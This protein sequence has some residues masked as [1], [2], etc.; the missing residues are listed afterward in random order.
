MSAHFTPHLLFHPRR[1]IMKKVAVISIVLMLCSSFAYAGELIV[2]S[3]HSDP[4]PKE[5]F[6]MLV[7]EFEKQNPDID[8]K[9]NTTAHEEYKKSIRIW[10]ASDNPPDV[11]TW[12]AGNRAMFF[13]EKD[14]IMDISDVWESAGL[15]DKFPKAFQSISF[16]DGKA[17]FLPDTYYWWAVYYRKSIFD[18]KGLTPPKTW[19]ELMQVCATLK[20]AGITPFTIGTKYR[21]TAA[22]WFDYFDMRVNGTK[23]HMDLMFGKVPYNDPKVAKAF[24]PW[25][26]MLDKGYFLENA[27]SYSWQEALQFMVRGEAAM[28]LMGQFIMDSVPEEVKADMDF[29]QFPIIDANVPVGE[30]A[31]TD[32]YMIPKKARNPEAAKK[33]MA[34]LASEQAQRIQVEKTG[35]I[36]TN[37][38]IPLD[39]YPEATQKG[40]QMMQSV[41]ELAQFYD[42]DT[43]PEMA[44]KGMDGMM[45]FWYKPGN[46]GKIL[47]RLE[48]DR[49]RIFAMPEE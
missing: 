29:F 32:G 27:A 21:W 6:E 46:L 43:N 2:N 9:V 35:R 14:L 30:D 40:I 37:K 10:L 38:D 39:L 34:F 13:I 31:P 11:I 48:K 23:F 3:M 22:A 42:R 26:E 5:T 45:E 16:K 18:E 8:V 15:M 47:D 28:Y 49:A 33:F 19:A 25:Q 1:N 12:F 20:D 36:V 7:A 41:D 17:Y 44:D 4:L 24:E